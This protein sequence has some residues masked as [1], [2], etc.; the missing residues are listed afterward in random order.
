[1]STGRKIVFGIAA[2][3]GAIAA[4]LASQWF[5]YIAEQNK[6][7]VELPSPVKLTT[8]VVARQTLG[9]GKSISHNMLQEIEWPINAVPPGAFTKISQL[10]AGNGSRVVLSHIVHNE[11]VLS[12]KIS[13]PGQ[14]ASLAA[15][16]KPDT[17]AVTIRVN[18]VNGVGGFVLP[19]DRVDI[20]LTRV[21]EKK[22]NGAEATVFNHVILQNIHV[23]AVDQT[24]DDRYNKP[25]LAKTVTVEVDIRNAQK[26]ALSAS[27]GNLSLLLRQPGSGQQNP[28]QKISV[29][30]LLEP[31]LINVEPK[32]GNELVAKTE[33][34]RDTEEVKEVLMRGRIKA[35]EVKIK[36]I[37]ALSVSEY[38][39]ISELSND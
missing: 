23:L 39:V 15:M 38:D 16:L 35:R 1:M 14:R 22:K 18:D 19:G 33:S 31:G 2:A 7:I 21:A 10:M 25:L 13:G 6:T 4:I 37:R 5:D 3:C 17:K 30:D 11:P 28:I 36:V 26:L 9:Y 20:L 24:A 8:V 32:F 12:S 27:V 34:N 29:K